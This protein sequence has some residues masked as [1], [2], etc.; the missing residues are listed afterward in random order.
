MKNILLT[1]S[2]SLI[3]LISFSSSAEIALKSEYQ[4]PAVSVNKNISLVIRVLCLDEEIIVM[5]SNTKG[6]D[7]TPANESCRKESDY[8][9]NRILDQELV[10]G[11]NL[12]PNTTGLIRRFLIYNKYYLVYSGKSGKPVIKQG[13]GHENT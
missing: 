11:K 4:V 9:V 10:Y 8:S 7:I 5:A 1:V 13:R 3:L 6:A 2:Y 12:A